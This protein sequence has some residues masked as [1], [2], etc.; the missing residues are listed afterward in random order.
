VLPYLLD[1]GGRRLDAILVTHTDYDHLGG[2]LAI[3]DSMSVGEIWVGS[4]RWDRAL[5]RVFREHAERRK[6]P[7]R[8]LHPRERF[9]LGGALFEV[10]AAGDV[11]DGESVESE[12]DRSVVLGIRFGNSRVL[13]TGDAGVRVEQAL[14]R[15]GASLEAD[16]LKVGHH[17]SLGSTSPDFVDRVR[18]RLAL[19]SARPSPGRTLPSEV[20]VDRLRERGIEGLRTDERGAITVRLDANGGIDVR[21]RRPGAPP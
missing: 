20:I 1:H 13:L 14:L 11:L 10:L 19:A 5:Y 2:L 12:N 9:E 8:R 4:P 7:V 21:T 6:L 15:R 18:P 3:V 16:V 17:G